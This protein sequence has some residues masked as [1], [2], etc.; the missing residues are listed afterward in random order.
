MSMFRAAVV[1]TLSL[2]AAVAIPA[3]RTN[4]DNA[5][6]FSFNA[7]KVGYPE[8]PS[9]DYLWAPTDGSSTGTAAGVDGG[10]DFWEGL[11]VAGMAIEGLMR[12]TSPGSSRFQSSNPRPSLPFSEPY[13][14]SR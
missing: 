6:G 12:P 5:I 4:P 9:L 8:S 14:A 13:Q 10:S 2:T 1:G 3:I 11:L 7:R